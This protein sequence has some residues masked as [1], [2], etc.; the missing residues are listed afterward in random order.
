MVENKS[1]KTPL[2][3]LTIAS[4]F[5]LSSAQSRLGHEV[6]AQEVPRYTYVQYDTEWYAQQMLAWKDVLKRQ[7]KNEIAW[8][9]YF[10][11]HRYHRISGGK[12]HEQTPKEI[13]AEMR[14]QIDGTWEYMRCALFEA[15]KGHEELELLAKMKELRPELD[16]DLYSYYITAYEWIGE[17]EKAK[18]SYKDLAESNYMSPALIEW[19]YNMLMSCEENAI[20]ITAGDNDTYPSRMLQE[21]A[22]VRPDVCVV[23]LS[24]SLQKSW[25][26]DMFEKWNIRYNEAQLIENQGYGPFA[27]SYFDEL[28]RA[29]PDRPLYLAICV[30]SWI[31]DSLQDNLYNE[32]LANRYSQTK[33]KNM[34]TLERNWFERFHTDYLDLYLTSIHHPQVSVTIPND[35]NYLPALTTLYPRLKGERKESVGRVIMNISKRAGREEGIEDFLN[36]N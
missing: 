11:A 15:K 10:F 33:I 28:M 4:A 2:L 9:N 35:L 1:M 20:L 26:N 7:P 29:N 16:P 23:N 14:T 21:A 36:R 34:A 6:L 8:Q 17:W 24:L 3:L 22:G 12:G 19:N 25:R 13:L 5:L 30:P 18:E 32:G 27:Y 31:T